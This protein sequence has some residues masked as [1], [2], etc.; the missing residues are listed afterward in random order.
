MARANADQPEARRQGENPRPGTEKSEGTAPLVEK[1][2]AGIGATLLL[3]SIGY[4]L[5]QSL[6]PSSPPD[7]VIEEEAAFVSP[8]GFIVTFEARN[9]GG[10]TASQTVVTGTLRRDGQDIEEREVTLDYVPANSSRR[11]GL[12]FENDPA[13]GELSLR[14]DGYVQP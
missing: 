14:A 8:N 1:I 12:F 11:G 2:A 4:T 9:R 7:V 10:E 13:S 3:G 5:Y 6:K